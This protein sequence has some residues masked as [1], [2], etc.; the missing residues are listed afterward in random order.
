MRVAAERRGER[1]PQQSQAAGF[2]FTLSQG[3]QFIDVAQRNGRLRPERRQQTD[4]ERCIADHLERS[5]GAG[6]IAGHDQQGYRH[7]ALTFNWRGAAGDNRQVILRDDAIPKPGLLRAV[8]RQ[9]HA[10]VIPDPQ[11]DAHRQGLVGSRG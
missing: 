8:G 5:D 6:D 10:H 11:R 4:V 9:Q 7:H 2:S 1:P 3:S